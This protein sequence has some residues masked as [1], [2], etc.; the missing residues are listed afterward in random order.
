[1]KIKKETA[2]ALLELFEV[3]TDTT[4]WEDD[5]FD[6]ERLEF[7]LVSCEL[8]DTTRWSHVHEVVYKDLLTGKFWMSSYRTGATECQDESPYEYDGD[9]IELTE[10]VP[11]EIKTTIYKAVK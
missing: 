8:V 6:G 11:V 4:D 2:Q 3:G 1:M 5:W 9:E 10:V 7:S